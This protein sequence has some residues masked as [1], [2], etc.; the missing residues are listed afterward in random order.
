[1]PA[2]KG[3]QHA[4][5]FCPRNL[6]TIDHEQGN[7]VILCFIPRH[8]AS[9]YHLIGDPHPETIHLSMLGAGGSVIVAPWGTWRLC[10]LNAPKKMRPLPWKRRNAGGRRDPYILA[11]SG[12]A[13]SGKPRT[14]A[15]VLERNDVPSVACSHTIVCV[16][17]LTEVTVWSGN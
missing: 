9:H 11:I 5:E 14:I 13:A 3:H 16:G 8:R 15:G 12:R 1:L 7:T 4:A 2:L 17:R 10:E 6:P